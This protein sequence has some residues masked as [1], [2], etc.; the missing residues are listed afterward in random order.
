MYKE[1]DKSHAI[2]L[3]S[4]LYIEDDE[5]HANIGSTSDVIS[6]Y[7]NCGFLLHRSLM[8]F[9]HSLT[10]VTNKPTLVRE[11]MEQEEIDLEVVQIEFTLHVPSTLKFR[12]AHRK[13][14][15]I[16]AFG[17][18]QLG[19]R[20]GY[21]DLDMVM[22]NKLPFSTIDDECLIGYNIWHHV[23]PAYGA[24]KIRYD[25]AK[26][27]GCNADDLKQWWGG[28]FLIGPRESFAMLSKQID[29]IYSQ[30]LKIASELHHQGDE[31]VVT[32]ALHSLARDNA[33]GIS[34]F[35]ADGGNMGAVGRWWSS[36]TL[37]RIEPLG[38][39]IN[40]SIIHLPADKDILSE[41]GANPILYGKGLARY[42]TGRL[43]RKTRWK[44]LLRPIFALAYSRK[45]TP[46]L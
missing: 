32:A 4:L 21:L 26:I 38:N 41:L 35:I 34:D 39:L 24:D 37:S 29:V 33:E 27:S 12:S 16:S 44:R 3:Y 7:L 14:D 20:P 45:F 36:R 15:L 13:I 1:K 30:Y 46:K 25:V 40:C 19:A 5:R 43:R 10:I 23:A 42:L 22:L 28:E 18:G 2:S 8:R 11:M 17:S 6:T 31:M 9:G